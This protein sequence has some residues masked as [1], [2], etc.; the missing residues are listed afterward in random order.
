MKQP[1]ARPPFDISYP[2]GDIGESELDWAPVSETNQ[3]MNNP[4]ST[5]CN[6]DVRV[7]SAGEGTCS[8]ECVRCG[9]A[10]DCRDSSMDD[11][12]QTHKRAIEWLLLSDEGLRLRL[13]ELSASEIRTVRAVLGAITSKTW[14]MKKT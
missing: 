3:A 13:G 10:C 12:A 14:L 7:Y 2:M 11:H 8:W 5:C 4:S 9:K 1:K 6:A